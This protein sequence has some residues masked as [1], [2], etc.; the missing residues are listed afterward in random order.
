ML[1]E[2]GTLYYRYGV[3]VGAGH[4]PRS[5]EV[6]LLLCLGVSRAARFQTVQTLAVE[7]TF[8]LLLLANLLFQRLLLLGLASR[9]RAIDN[10]IAV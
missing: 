10:K 5:I 8:S 1:T 2:R 7:H 3:G 4:L 6:G 9:C